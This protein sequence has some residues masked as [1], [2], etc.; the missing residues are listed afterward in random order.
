MKCFLRKKKRLGKGEKS[1]KHLRRGVSHR[2]LYC[3]HCSCFCKDEDQLQS[4]VAATHSSREDLCR[5]P[6]HKWEQDMGFRITTA[7]N[8]AK[9]MKILPPN[10]KRGPQQA[11]LKAQKASSEYYLDWET[12]CLFA[13][14]IIVCAASLI[15][16]Q[17]RSWEP[18]ARK[19]LL[20][21]KQKVDEYRA[22]LGLQVIF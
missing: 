20:N 10:G 13:Q 21:F 9:S 3:Q 5:I 1:H 14:N 7:R 19:W 6:A 11:H 16:P 12:S 2:H 8:L 18:T 17:I 4:R 22:L 15:L